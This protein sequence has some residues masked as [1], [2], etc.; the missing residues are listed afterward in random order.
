MLGDLG[1]QGL[2]PRLP[3]LSTSKQA[4]VLLRRPQEALTCRDVG[5][6]LPGARPVPLND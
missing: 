2:Q 3:G 1:S 4:A 5:W 6:W